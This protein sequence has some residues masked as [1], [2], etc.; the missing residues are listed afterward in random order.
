MTAAIPFIH[1]SPEWHALRAK[2]VGG[3]EIAALFDLPRDDVPAYLVSRFALWHVKAGNAPSPFVDNPR[4]KWGLKLEA[5]IA[6]AAAE[7]QGWE[8][9]KGGYVIDSTCKGLGCTLD[10]VIA[11]D[12]DEDGPGDLECKNVDWLVHRRSWEVDDEPPLHILLQ[13]QHQMAATGHSWGAVAALVG[14]NDLRIYR[15]RA[16][17]TLIA[18]IRQKVTE[19][20]ASIEANQ[21]PSADGS[22]SAA[23]ILRSLF[24]EIMDDAHDFSSNNEW[25]GAAHEF[26][27]AAAARKEANAVY[28]DTKNRIVELLGPHKRGFGNGWTINTAITPENH[29]RLPKEGELIGV[30]KEVRRYTVKEMT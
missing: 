15:Y 13:H 2:H 21:P 20:W 6:E 7:T 1:D 11:S 24:P 19:F 9:S 4:A 28:D 29:G 25:A 23:D 26:Y 30:R 10:Y 8:V 27:N 17:P 14:G 16:R 3:S 18:T 5:V 12:P 22:D